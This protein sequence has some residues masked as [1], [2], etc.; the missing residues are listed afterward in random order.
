[1]ELILRSDIFKQNT[2]LHFESEIIPANYIFM[3][4]LCSGLRQKRHGKTIMMIIYHENIYVVCALCNGEKILIWSYETFPCVKP[5]VQGAPFMEA[6]PI[7]WSKT[8][9][10]P[11]TRHN[12]IECK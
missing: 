11:A 8:A 12:N 10:A 3:Q 1:M 5:T 2:S 4:T 6:D 7:T 9:I